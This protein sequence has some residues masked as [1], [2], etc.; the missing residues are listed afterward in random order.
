VY[1]EIFI[2]GHYRGGIFVSPH[3]RKVKVKG[4]KHLKNTVKSYM[5]TDPG[6]LTFN[7][8]GKTQ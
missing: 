6:Q 1:K 7:F 4:Y 3:I 2:K 5:S 8:T